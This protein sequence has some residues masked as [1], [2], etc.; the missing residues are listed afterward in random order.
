[1]RTTGRRLAV[2]AL[3]LATAVAAQAQC[4]FKRIATI[5]I[6][7]RDDR[8]TVDGSVNGTRLRMAV[9]D[10]VKWPILPCPWF[11]RRGCVRRR[12][13]RRRGRSA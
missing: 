5:P 13:G 10:R 2:A 11:S 6:E 3:L 9:A 1:M 8:L 12:A 7:W 4:K